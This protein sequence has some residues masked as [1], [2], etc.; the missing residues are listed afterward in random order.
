M[1]EDNHKNYQPTGEEL[2]ILQILWEEGEA[3]VREVNEQLNLRY[4][5]QSGYTT[6]LKFMQLM[7]G[8]GLLDRRKEGKTHIYRALLTEQTT[9]KQ[10]LDSLIEKAFHGSARRLVLQALGNRKTSKKDLKE[11]RDFLDQLEDS[12]EGS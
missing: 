10:L 12:S 6:T 4:E 7:H 2:K 9:Q 11:I 3:T 8:K 5:K 1:P